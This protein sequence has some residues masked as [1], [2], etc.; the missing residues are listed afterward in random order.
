MYQNEKSISVPFIE[1][2]ET[3]NEHEFTSEM[4]SKASKGN[5]DSLN[6]PESYPYRPE[7]SFMIARSKKYLALRFEVKGLDLRATQM[8]DNG[9]S[10]EDSCCE[11]FISP[12]GKEYYNIEVTCIGSI[13]MAHGGGRD[14][15]KTLRDTEVAKIIRR[16]SL[17]HKAYDISDE[18]REWTLSLIIPF[19]LIGLNPKALP[20]SVRGNFYKCGDLTAHP[21]YLSWSPITTEN[22][23]FH[24][25]EFFGTISF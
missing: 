14:G 21:H 1:G 8:K 9:R 6:W 18:E 24:R 15:R 3:M 20:A 23:D 11:F 10:W 17:E 13:L 7:C 19:K 16:S 5:V 25:P 4:V 22:P 12:D 2:L